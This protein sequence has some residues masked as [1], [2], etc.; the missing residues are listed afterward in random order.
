M[1]KILVAK[2]RDAQR[3]EPANV[4]FSWLAFLV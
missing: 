1:L 2:N 4:A 3:P